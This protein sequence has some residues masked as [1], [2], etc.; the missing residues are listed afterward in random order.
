MT[1]DQD[2]WREQWR[3]AMRTEPPAEMTPDEMSATLRRLFA[4][5]ENAEPETYFPG[6]DPDGKPRLDPFCVGFVA[7]GSAMP[8]ESEDDDLRARQGRTQRSPFV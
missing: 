6:V 4:E 3:R 1:T 8:V 2:L 5:A 7:E